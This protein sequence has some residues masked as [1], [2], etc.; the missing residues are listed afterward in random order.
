MRCL[1]CGKGSE[2]FMIISRPDGDYSK[3][4][5]YCSYICSA[6]YTELDY[7]YLQFLRN[8]KPDLVEE[9]VNKQLGTSSSLLRLKSVK[10][11]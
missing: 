8:N 7:D 11:N 10:D 4:G 9:V 1:F 3:Y 5:D 2:S 6:R